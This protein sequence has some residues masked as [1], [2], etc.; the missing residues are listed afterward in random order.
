VFGDLVDGRVFYTNAADMVRGAGL[1]PL[2]QLRIV[3]SGGTQTTM[4][5]LAGDNRVDMRLGLDHAGELYV[6]SKANGRL[7]KVTATRGSA[8]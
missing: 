3:N 1:A 7:W 8:P 5:S 6:L 2:C 4:Q